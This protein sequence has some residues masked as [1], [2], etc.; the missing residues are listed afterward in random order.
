LFE[1]L[2]E[3][4]VHVPDQRLGHGAQHTRVH[5]A[6]AGAHQETLRR[7][8]FTG[9]EGRRSIRCSHRES[10]LREKTGRLPEL[11]SGAIHGH[12]NSSVAKVAASKQ[13]KSLSDAFVR[14]KWSEEA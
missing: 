14:I 10:F 8:E 13:R 11:T 6:G 3:R 12:K 7:V 9:R 5:V 1:Y 2:H 4:R